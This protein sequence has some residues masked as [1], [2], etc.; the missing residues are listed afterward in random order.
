[1]AL[2]KRKR[3]KLTDKNSETSTNNMIESEEQ[4]HGLPYYL[5]RLK[6]IQKKGSRAQQLKSDIEIKGTSKYPQITIN[7]DAARYEIIKKVLPVKIKG[8]GLLVKDK[9]SSINPK[10]FTVNVAMLK[11]VPLDVIDA[12]LEEQVQ[13]QFP[14]A[15]TIRLQKNGKPLRTFRVKFINSAKLLTAINLRGF[16]LPSEQI[17]CRFEKHIDG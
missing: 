3:K 16:L 8:L 1:M 14:G 11:G 9:T 15:T 4:H 2:F 7:L 17:I 12:E 5:N 13:S 6:A 10:T